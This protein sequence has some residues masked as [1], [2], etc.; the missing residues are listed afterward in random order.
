MFACLR[1]CANSV[2]CVVKTGER[3]GETSMNGFA[4]LNRE[5]VILLLSLVGAGAFGVTTSL[6]VMARAFPALKDLR[7]AA[8]D[9]DEL[10]SRHPQIGSRAPLETKA[11][12]LVGNKLRL[13]DGSYVAAYR[14][15]AAETLYSPHDTQHDL[16]RRLTLLMQE[17]FPV[18]T[19]FQ[20]RQSVLP[21]HGL[22]VIRHAER[23]ALLPPPPD[24]S[25]LLL[26][27][28]H[29]RNVNEYAGRV[30]G[31]Q[32]RRVICT[33]WVRV[34]V[35]EVKPGLKLFWTEL[36]S[37]MRRKSFSPAKL[38]EALLDER[39][40][41]RFRD[42]EIRA[43]RK[44]EDYFDTI[45]RICPYTL[46][47]MD[48]QELWKA[49]YTSHN[50][51]ALDAPQPPGP[52]RDLQ[53][54]A[55]EEDVIFGDT[56][57]LHGHQPVTVVSMTLLPQ[58][59]TDAR[60]LGTY[61]GIM[62]PLTASPLLTFRHC[63]ISEYVVVDQAK[64]RRQY[65]SMMEWTRSTG[66]NF[67]RGT[68]TAEAQKKYFQLREIRDDMANGTIRILALRHR[69]LVYGTPVS[70]AEKRAF[71][72][73]MVLSEDGEAELTA[74][75]KEIL[76]SY[77][78]VPGV[79]AIRE[80]AAS[81]LVLY[82]LSLAGELSELPVGRELEEV[83]ISLSPMAM[84]ER[85]WSPSETMHTFF[86]SISGHLVGLDLF[87]AGAV[88]PPTMAIFGETKSGKSLLAGSLAMDA[89]ATYPECRAQIIDFNSFARMG[90]ITGAT[91][92]QFHPDDKRG[93]NVWYYD[94]LHDG[95]DVEEE[96]ITLVLGD[97]KRLAGVPIE[98]NLTDALLEPVVREVYA[99]VLAD[100]R[101]FRGKREPVEPTVST[102]LEFLETAVRG[103]MFPTQ[104][105]T[106]A[107]ENIRIRLLRYRGN[108]WID[109]PM[110][111]SFITD[112]RMV[113]YDMETLPL[114]TEDIRRTLAYRVAVRVVRSIGNR[115]GASR[116][117]RI[118]IF[119]EM[120]RISSDYPE[121]LFA[122]EKGT[123]QGRK[124]NVFTMFLAQNYE[125]AERIPGIIKNIGLKIIGKQNGDNRK[126]M[127]D[128]KLSEEAA[129][130]VTNI[131]NVPGR[132]S[133][134]LFVSGQGI[135]QKVE[136]AQY[137]VSA[138]YLWL[139]TTDPNETTVFNE[140]EKKL[141]SKT[142]A[143]EFLCRRYPHG[144]SYEKRTTLSTKDRE[145]LER[146]ALR[147]RRAAAA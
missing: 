117:P 136:F 84:L 110:H 83:A 123:R 55:N 21:E 86:R 4:E 71:V 109:A 53:L 20:F 12:A 115:I 45:A 91:F 28:Y 13:M 80:S 33:L 7:Y 11:V 101:L 114:F 30:K 138:T 2:D 141:G 34:P 6:G 18:G 17:E 22:S 143:L 51:D 48:K 50:E 140:V 64:R 3:S 88:R 70:P 57:V 78:T 56:C 68:M 49:Y 124:E 24:E 73:R 79:Q 128:F 9:W 87:E 40:R 89:L 85:P 66:V 76:N 147:L 125:D 61:P 95:E 130:M 72:E 52:D 58:A 146:L 8:P 23:L 82:P 99:S 74:R 108:P 118:N 100:N 62:R 127:E 39:L 35:L 10:L 31:G 144:L 111:P 133:Q 135:D 122:I 63:I 54:Y 43:A 77:K 32:Y 27:S 96:Q 134:F 65:D 69:V 37:Q 16:C 41:K 14:L 92:F 119:D 1:N 46:R 145:D 42:E 59:S 105:M 139:L 81:Q 67:F 116:P 98:D 106:D 60:H 90:Q 103:R 5:E 132:H 137:E 97:I 26:G 36:R 25:S 93:F 121:I 126:M 38:I 94:G 47:R 112:S 131:L 120:V 19:V 142:A 107:A 104:T 75:C 102:F 44:A 29:S 15:D 113:I 129:E